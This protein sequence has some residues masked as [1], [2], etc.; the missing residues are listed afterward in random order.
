MRGQVAIKLSQLGLGLPTLHTS[1]NISRFTPKLSRRYLSTF[2]KKK[3][4]ALVIWGINLTSTVGEKFSLQELKMIQFPPY[5]YSVVIGLLLSD[6][7][8]TFSNVRAKN[9]RLGFKQSVNNMSYVSFVFFLLS[10]YCS[11]MPS[12]SKGRVRGDKLEHYFYFVTRSLSV[13]TGLH[14]IFYVNKVKVIPNDIYNLLTPV[15]LAHMIMGDGSAERHGL[16]LCTDSFTIPDVI[17]LINVLIIRYQLDCAFRLHTPT[18]P[19]IYIKEGSM[20]KLRAIVEPYMHHA[21]M[22]KLNNNLVDKEGNPVKNK[23]NNKVKVLDEAGGLVYNFPSVTECALF[24]N[25]DRRTIN[26]RTF[27]GSFMKFKGKNLKFEFD[28]N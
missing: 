2:N 12:M 11:S 1:I 5:Q 23:K 13:F 17:K 10:H 19:R 22:Y 9:A 21:L 25:V 14:S 15:A 20:A 8:L 16:I 4:T 26:R 3:N 7:W 27:T 24:F 18:Q 28:V 6:G